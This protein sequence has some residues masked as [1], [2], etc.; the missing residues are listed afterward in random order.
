MRIRKS[1]DKKRGEIVFH[2]ISSTGEID[3]SFRFKAP[4][5]TYVDFWLKHLGQEIEEMKAKLNELEKIIRKLLKS[6]G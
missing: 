6:M 5:S 2:V 1:E 3:K 4:E